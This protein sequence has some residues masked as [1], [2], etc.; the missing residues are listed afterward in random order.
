MELT[1]LPCEI[2]ERGFDWLCD[3]VASAF[4]NEPPHRELT[5]SDLPP[6]IIYIII[7]H[8]T[9]TK[10]LY[11][12]FLQ[13]D[14]LSLSNTSRALRAQCLPHLFQEL[15]VRFTLATP[16]HDPRPADAPCEPACRTHAIWADARP[17]TG[18]PTLARLARFL[19]HSPHVAPH[20]RLLALEARSAHALCAA[21]R[22]GHP[23]AREGVVARA[24]LLRVLALLPRLR[25]LQLIDVRVAE[26]GAPAVAL[27]PVRAE[28]QHL[29]ISFS[30]QTSARAGNVELRHAIGALGL[31]R[32]VDVLHLGPFLTCETGSAIVIP[33]GVT[34]RALFLRNP[35]PMRGTLAA[36]V[37]APRLGLEALDVGDAWTVHTVEDEVMALMEGGPLVEGD[38]ADTDVVAAV[39]ALLRASGGGLTHLGL[40]AMTLCHHAFL[41]GSPAERVFEDCVFAWCPNL[42]SLALTVAIS[43]HR[44]GRTQP[45]LA[46]TAQLL[47]ALTRDHGRLPSLRALTLSVELASLRSPHGASEHGWLTRGLDAHRAL[48]GRIDGAL[49]GLAGALDVAFVASEAEPCNL[50]VAA[51]TEVYFPAVLPRA[52]AKMRGVPSDSPWAV[53]RRLSMA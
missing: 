33:G 9:S 38:A 37:A 2:A 41:A 23:R 30:S 17:A 39:R 51:L 35:W 7:S 46:H 18:T 14:I 12:Y 24:D 10:P 20:V 16:P 15:R 6:D 32:A 49:A 40:G 1:T 47:E 53:R 4:P 31:F 43:A 50:D 28:I 27:K 3:F 48:F 21:D 45:M 44:P 34:V 13:P 26:L 36:L 8:L 22:C 5:L 42:S 11:I 29:R 25:A 52:W 19:A